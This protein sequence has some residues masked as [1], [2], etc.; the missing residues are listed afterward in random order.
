M[1]PFLAPSRLTGSKIAR[2]VNLVIEQLEGRVLLS[3]TL[4]AAVHASTDAVYSVTGDPTGGYAVTLSAGTYAF[5]ANVG[6]AGGDL[7]NLTLTLTNSAVA[8]FNSPETLSGLSLS[9]TSKLTATSSGGGSAGNVL[10]VGTGGFSMPLDPTTNL[11]TATLD[12]MDNDMLLQ[13]AGSSELPV[14]Q[15]LLKSGLP[16][17]GTGLRSSDAAASPTTYKYA[18]G[19]ALNGTSVN[20]STFD[21][22]PAA[23][24]DVLVRYTLAGDVNL[25]SRVNATDYGILALRESR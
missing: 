13:G 16:T 18:L 7:P 15:A 3:G 17:A 23:A 5:D 9:G 14:L 20:Y 4:P 24:G 10:S 2:A 22:L 6:A 19:Y 25:D 1:I 21:G 11:P 12:L 8:A